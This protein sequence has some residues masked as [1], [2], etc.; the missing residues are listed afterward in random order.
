MKA[1]N[2][3]KILY[4]IPSRIRK[5][6]LL[7]I[8]TLCLIFSLYLADSYYSSSLQNFNKIIYIFVV[9]ISLALYFFSGQYNILNRYI[10]FSG[11]YLVLIRNTLLSIL[12][13]L[14]P[15]FLGFNYFPISYVLLFWI[16]LGE[17][18]L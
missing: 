7:L 9:P 1:D 6:I 10:N 18:F 14:I 5:V 2:F 3:K 15:K 16:F 11:I 17:V 4:S 13:Y 12:I 8:D